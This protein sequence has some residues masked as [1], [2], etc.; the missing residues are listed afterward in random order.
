L[1][2]LHPTFEIHCRSS[3]SDPATGCQAINGAT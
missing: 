1:L 2:D 3:Q